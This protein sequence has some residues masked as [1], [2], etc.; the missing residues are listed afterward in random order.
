M[1]LLL[2]VEVVALELGHVSLEGRDV[3]LQDTPQSSD[4]QHIAWNEENIEIEGGYKLCAGL[5]KHLERMQSLGRTHGP[6]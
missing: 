2:V 6:E 1:A 3:L 5:R 4:F